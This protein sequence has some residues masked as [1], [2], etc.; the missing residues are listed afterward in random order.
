MQP[1]RL[2]SDEALRGIA[3]LLVVLYHGERRFE[4]TAGFALFEAGRF[5]V[6]I[7]FVI[8]GFVMVIATAGPSQP[9][10]FI[11]SRI[12]RIAPIYWLATC[13]A[14]VILLIDPSALKYTAVSVK[15]FVLS[16][17]FI[18]HANPGNPGVP[19]PLY[20]VGWTLNFEMYF[21][22]CLAIGMAI[23]H[24]YRAVIA[25][26]FVL[27]FVLLRNLGFANTV[28][29]DFIG[30]EIALEFIFGMAMAWGW[31][32]KRLPILP[33]PLAVP[34]LL[35][36][37]LGPF[38]LAQSPLP[39]LILHGGAATLCLWTVL[40]IEPFMQHKSA[41]FALNL[42]RASYSL[43]LSHIFT[44]LA[45]GAF[46]PPPDDLTGVLCFV[47]MACIFS[48]AVAFALYQWIEAPL[49]RMTRKTIK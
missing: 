16:L 15:S 9:I 35:C 39:D 12:L 3:A 38:L 29:L 8:S 28:Q 31:Q 46:W 48:V 33:F 7:F 13:L 42:G 21:Y 4:E 2:H 37:L 44:L 27:S 22:L 25:A 5:G 1:N 26:G 30:S 45:V 43:Y 14:A 19:T 34:V 6:D 41:G 18:P 47:A 32:A 17:A 23:S 24:R 40:S 11:K 36:A 20:T 49:M 10:D